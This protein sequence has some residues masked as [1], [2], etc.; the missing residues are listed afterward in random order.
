MWRSVKAGFGVRPIGGLS[1][2][3]EFFGG[4]KTIILRQE[5]AFVIMG[6]EGRLL[7]TEGTEGN[8]RGA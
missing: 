2:I 7:G 5:K 8:V 1:V 3:T 4:Y 6:P